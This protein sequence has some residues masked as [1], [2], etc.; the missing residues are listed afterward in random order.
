MSAQ[1]KLNA[2]GSVALPDL[3]WSTNT[4][5]GLFLNTNTINI[6]SGGQSCGQFDNTSINTCTTKS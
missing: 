6:V 4:N 1:L 3:T 5:T 2:G